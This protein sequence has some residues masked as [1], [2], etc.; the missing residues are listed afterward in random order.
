LKTVPQR[1]PGSALVLRR[2]V[3]AMTRTTRRRLILLA[4]LAAVGYARGPYL[5]E[6]HGA[7][8]IPDR[9]QY[10]PKRQFE[11]AT[12]PPPDYPTQRVEDTYASEPFAT[13]FESRRTA[14]LDLCAR[15]PGGPYAQL[16]RLAAGA[17]PHEGVIHANA[18][19]DID[20]R[21]DCADFR[22]HAVLRLL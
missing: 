1:S 12:K 4:L 16:A 19:D 10:V 11:R 3:P 2:E 5:M 21:L 20:Q 7:A 17:T 14:Y 8:D 9:P 15:S 13:D 22:L 18:L 6:H